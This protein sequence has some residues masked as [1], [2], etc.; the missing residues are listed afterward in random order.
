VG[1]I[2]AHP[3]PA[4]AALDGCRTPDQSYRAIMIAV[5]AMSGT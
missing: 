4:A 3:C 1:A 5:V 2:D